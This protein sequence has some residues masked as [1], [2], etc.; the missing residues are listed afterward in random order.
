MKKIEKGCIKESIKAFRMPR[1]K[2]LPDV[3][4]YLD[5]TT[6]Y[7]NSFL[8]PLGLEIT[9]SMISNYVKKGLITNP[10][11]KQYSA[12]QIAYL[13]FIAIAK[14]ALSMENI[15][16]LLDIQKELYEPQVAYDYFCTEFENML[17]YIFG[18]SNEVKEVGVTNTEAKQMCRSLIIAV[19][20]I[21]HLKTFFEKVDNEGW[22]YNY[23]A[24]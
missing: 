15:K 18:I 11:K 24:Q 21:V 19:V 14:N 12:Q 22:F 9:G 3:G 10:L 23:C 8:A 5:Q 7:I 2:E 1:F 6:K 17:F 4:L 20:H 16:K 13:F